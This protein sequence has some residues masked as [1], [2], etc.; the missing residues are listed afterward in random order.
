MIPTVEFRISP[1]SRTHP[2]YSKVSLW[3]LYQTCPLSRGGQACLKAC[4]AIN[5]CKR[6]V[7][8]SRNKYHQLS[9]KTKTCQRPKVLT[10]SVTLKDRIFY[11]PNNCK[12]MF[13]IK[14]QT[15]ASNLQSTHKPHSL[16]GGSILIRSLSTGFAWLHPGLQSGHP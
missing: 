15:N 6:C 4:N 11:F 13:E 9:S 14:F 12:T 16:F 8:K 2:C 1:G 10:A 3:D 5:A 7:H